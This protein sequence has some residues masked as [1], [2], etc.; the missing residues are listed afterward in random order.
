MVN[1]SFL[2]LNTCKII[3]LNMIFSKALNLGANCARELLQSNT[4]FA[5]TTLA[6]N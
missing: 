2:Y 5:N 1:I 4:T 3:S 6:N